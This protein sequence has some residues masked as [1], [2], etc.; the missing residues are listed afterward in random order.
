MKHSAKVGDVVQITFHDHVEVAGIETPDVIEFVV[1]GVLCEKSR[2]KLVVRSW[3][4]AD[5]ITRVDE[6]VHSWVI[7]R[8]AVTDVRV[9]K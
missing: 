4:Y 3:V 5:D 1:Y 7:A 8:K 6:N 2:Q 9:L